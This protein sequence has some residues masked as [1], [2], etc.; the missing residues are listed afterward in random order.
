M[1]WDNWEDLPMDDSFF[2]QGAQI[3]SQDL[4]TDGA[5]G[6]L[7]LAKAAGLV[8]EVAQ[9]QNGPLVAQ[10]QEGGFDWAGG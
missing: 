8:K 3:G 10:E 9:D 4:L 7:Q 1:R 2:L 5:D 6:F